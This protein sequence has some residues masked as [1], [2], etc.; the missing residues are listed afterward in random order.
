LFFG[1]LKG[2]LRF[3]PDTLQER[4]APL[5]IVL[6]EIRK[7]EQPFPLGPDL[8]RLAA[9]AFSWQDDL[10][11]FDFAALGLAQPQKA[12]YAWK[13]EGYDQEW[14]LGGTK[15]TATYTN[16]PGG[17][18]TLR[19]KATDETGRWHEN[20]LAVQLTVSTPPWHRWWAYLLYVLALTGILGGVM[21]YRLNQLHAVNKAKTQFTQ[22]L[23][24]SQEA[25]RKRI[26]AELH[27]GLGQSLLVIKNRTII[28]KRMANSDEKVTT[29]LE[30]ISKATGQALEEVRSIA[31]NLRPYHLERLGLRESIEAMLEKIREAMELE[32]NARVAL[33]DEVFSKD[34]EVLFYRVIQECLNNIIKHANATAVEISIVQTET[35]VTARIQDNGSGFVVAPERQSGGFGLIG[36]A[37]R[38]RMLGGTHSI[39]S[40]AGKG[41]IVIVKIPRDKE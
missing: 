30:E 29:Q 36:L 12:H 22:Q 33:F 6:T 32:I 13:L 14:I 28:G 39:S 37:E 5:T 1:T 17:R 3:Y 18:Y 34:D 23:I 7:F 8:S 24:T 35:E 15:R 10:L 20:Q 31:Y 16:L 2:L 41:T 38:I 26:A 25:E 19:V 21:R 9:L 11:S 4:A 27:D 40:E